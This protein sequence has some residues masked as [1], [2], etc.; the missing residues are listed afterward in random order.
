[1]KQLEG[2]S[3]GTEHIYQLIKTLYGLKQSGREWN[4]KFDKQIRCHNFKHL[5]SDL[6]AYI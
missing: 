4:I 2:F 3:D 6:C 1:M 5:Q